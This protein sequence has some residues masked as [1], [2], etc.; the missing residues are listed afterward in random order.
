MKRWR[1]KVHY[2]K[3][4]QSLVGGKTDVYEVD[5]LEELHNLVERGPDFNAIKK[6][7][8]RYQG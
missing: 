7:V 4:A 2:R 1:A 3:S 6:I 5:E 8:I